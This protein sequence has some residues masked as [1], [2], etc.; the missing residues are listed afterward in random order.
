M[1][2]GVHAGDPEQ[3]S[4]RACFPRIADAVAEHG[5]LLSALRTMRH[6][7]PSSRC[8]A[9]PAGGMEVLTNAAA[10]SLGDRLRLSNPVRGLSGSPGDWILRAEGGELRCRRVVLACSLAACRVLL[11]SAAPAAVEPLATMSAESLVSV[12]QLHSR[13]AVGHPLDGFGYL[14]P[15]RESLAHLGTLFSSTLDPDC[16]PPGHVL[17]R[18]LL[19]G[20][21]QPELVRRSDAELN[22]IVERE[23]YRLLSIRGTPLDSKI[24]RY[25]GAIP[26]Y[27]LDHP[28]RL[29]ALKRAL[30]P[31]LELLG[32]FTRGL[33]LDALVTSAFELARA[34]ERAC[35]T[36]RDAV[37]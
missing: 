11:E 4:L 27:D 16:V 14:V 7:D 23:V 1:V 3:L 10:A 25:L 34:D 21:R 18:T 19:G 26:R 5:S 12:V 35:G 36:A 30:P 17:L 29:A 22:D 31:G 2:A 6:A 24:S 15:A 37:R 33:G 9:R 20:A 13:A 32:N 28:A 8:P